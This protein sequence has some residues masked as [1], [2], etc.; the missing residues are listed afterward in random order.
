MITSG[1]STVRFDGREMKQRTP[2]DGR[3]CVRDGEAGLAV[4]RIHLEIV[5]V[6]GGLHAR[7]VRADPADGQ[8]RMD[9]RR[10][11]RLDARAEVVDLRQDGISQSEVDPGRREIDHDSQC[12]RGLKQ[13]LE[14][15]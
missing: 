10:H 4:A 7:P 1:P 2:G 13:D 3:A 14:C 12:K 5:D 11:H 15:V 9:L 8:A 6:E